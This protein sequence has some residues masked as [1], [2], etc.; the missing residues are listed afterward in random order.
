M[1]NRPPT[2]TS[3]TRGTYRDD[4]GTP[5]WILNLHRAIHGPVIDL[6]LASN[7]VDQE[8]IRARRFYSR[9]APCPDRPPISSGDIVWCN[10]PGPS[11]EVVRFWRIWCDC[12]ERGAAGAFLVF[13]VDHVR[14]LG[15]PH[16]ECWVGFLRRRPK[17]LGN[18]SS[19]TI[20]AALITT[21]P[22]TLAV[23]DL[24]VWMKWG[25]AL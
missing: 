25:G 11:K 13:S 6:D 4:H 7:S 21:K 10:P 3:R 9:K 24:A 22:P 1:S 5:D 14:M 15:Q 16:V 19:A 17:F 2:L 23:V 8:R 18:T 20:G 12:I